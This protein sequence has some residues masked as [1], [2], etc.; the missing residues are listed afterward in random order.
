MQELRKRIPYYNQR[1]AVKP[2]ITG[3]AQ[4]RFRYG[5]DETDAVEKLR[6]DMFY[7]KHHSILFDLR[8]LLE[9]VRVVFQRDM[10]R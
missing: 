2:G 10:G 3:W 5:A 7:I 1:H 9:T 4:V 6:H 8:I